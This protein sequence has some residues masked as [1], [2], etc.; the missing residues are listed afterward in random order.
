M[1]LCLSECQK[2]AI[3]IAVATLLSNSYLTEIDMNSLFE[4]MV[5]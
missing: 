2:M 1:K 5:M 4:D 3:K